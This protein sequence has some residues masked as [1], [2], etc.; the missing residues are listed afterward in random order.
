MKVDE[1][2]GPLSDVWARELFL[3]YFQ[4][5]S[6]TEPSNSF[7]YRRVEYSFGFFCR[8]RSRATL[9]NLPEL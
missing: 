2:I 6:Y 7:T 5:I 4:S 3:L 1:R 8:A 9:H